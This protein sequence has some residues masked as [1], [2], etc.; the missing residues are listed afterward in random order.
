MNDQARTAQVEVAKE[1][2]AD[3]L[4][5][6]INHTR[7]AVLR[8]VLV[9]SETGGTYAAQ[10]ARELKL[11]KG[12]VTKI[13]QTFE[14]DGIIHANKKKRSCLICNGRG[15]VRAETG[16]KKCLMCEGSGFTIEKS[17]PLFY[18]VVPAQAPN[19]KKLIYS[20]VDMYA[21]GSK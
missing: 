20:L 5:P 16:V 1:A 15:D 8:A 7:L 21:A 9:E 19:V 12:H 14:K 6:T 17:Y 10:V 13:L 18:V 11:D 2:V 4:C 3:R